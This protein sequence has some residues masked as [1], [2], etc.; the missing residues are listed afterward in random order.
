MERGG[1]GGRGR[2]REGD[3][4][5]LGDGEGG[6]RAVDREIIETEI[7]CGETKEGVDGDQG[8]R[9]GV[10]WREGKTK[11]KE[12]GEE[13]GD[14]RNGERVS[15][16]AGE[17]RRRA[18]ETEILKVRDMVKLGFVLKVQ[19]MVKLGGKEGGDD[20]SRH[21]GGNGNEERE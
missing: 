12:D 5:R 6:L 1:D 10:R 20:G 11:R 7:E 17:V 8:R 4:E 13:G 16:R 14:G 15:R 18:G 9:R 19:E 3:I 2:R 21:D